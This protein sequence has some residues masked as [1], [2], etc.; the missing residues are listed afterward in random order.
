MSTSFVPGVQWSSSSGAT[1]EPVYAELVRRHRLGEVSFS[2]VTTFNLDE[3]VGL[4]AD[5]PQT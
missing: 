4:P 2:R 1:M 5:H 3:Y